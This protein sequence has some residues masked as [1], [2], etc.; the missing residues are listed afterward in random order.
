M[1][2]SFVAVELGGSEI[3]DHLQK[4]EKARSA[5]VF[6][7]VCESTRGKKNSHYAPRSGAVILSNQTNI[8]YRIRFQIYPKKEAFIIHISFY[9]SPVTTRLNRF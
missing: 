1:E 9:Q 2:L 4:V 3:S 5:S 7:A 6:I 8:V